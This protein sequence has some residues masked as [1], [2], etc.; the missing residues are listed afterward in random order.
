[1][2]IRRHLGRPDALQR[3]ARPVLLAFAL[4]A[5]AAGTAQAEDDLR[6]AIVVPVAGSAFFDAVQ[7]G[8]AARVAQ[9]G[10]DHRTVTCLYGG[11]GFTLQTASAAQPYAGEPPA[12][13]PGGDQGGGQPV[14]DPGAPA[15]PTLD[16]RSEA[17]IVLDFVAAHVDGIAVSPAGDPAVSAAIVTAAKAGIP[18]VTF[19]SDAAQTARTAFIG[20]NARDFGRAL[21]ASLKRWKPKGGKYV[22]VSTDPSQPSMAE[23]IYGVR[24]AIGAGWNEIS[25]SPVVTTGAYPDAVTKIDHLLNTYYDVDAIISVGAWPMLATDDWRDMIARYK[26]RIDKADVVLVVADALPAQKDLV[27]QG[28]GHVLVGQRPTD[29]GARAADLLLSLKAGRRVPEVVYVGF[30]TFTRLD[31]VGQPN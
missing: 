18:V 24:D 3:L 14:V 28:L 31:L 29:M 2:R 17:Q 5:L 1:M 7:A 12:A 16:G 9:L 15:Q 13:A 25:D 26:A 22:I 6:L 23:R 8:C 21:A 19:D 20:T 10:R 4:A 11:P 30:E 27:R